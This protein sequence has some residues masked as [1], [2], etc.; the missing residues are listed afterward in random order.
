MPRPLVT[1]SIPTYNSGPFLQTC[2]EAIKEQTYKR[3][4][5]NIVDG[6]SKDDTLQ[7]ARKNGIKA[8]FSSKE[9]LLEARYIG[10]EHA[11]GKYVL[12]LDSDQILSPDTIERAVDLCEQSNTKIVIL[13]EGVYQPRTL[14][15]KLFQEDR[16]LVHRVK[17]F[18]P[19]TGVLLPRFYQ[20]DFLLK[21]MT[22]IPVEVRKAVGG[23]D[24]AIIYYEVWQ[25]SQ[26]VGYLPQAV[27]HIEPNSL[28]KIW[29]KFYRWGKTSVGA[30]LGKYD[31]MLEKKERFRTGL[32]KKGLVKASIASTILLLC[33]GIPYKLGYIMGQHQKRHD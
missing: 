13:E 2:L 33:K 27:S 22:N 29:R 30:R 25:L 11:K 24:H 26:D 31:V 19:S 15:E 17:D 4:E 8:I 1:I 16:R 14:I 9:A 12:L 18:N 21:A 5:I 7:I 20:R 32:F 6:G 23:Q 28:P 3:I 10:L